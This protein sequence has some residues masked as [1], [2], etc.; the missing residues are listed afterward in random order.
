MKFLRSVVA[1]L[2][3]PLTSR[4][5]SPLLF[6]LPF[7]RSIT[8]PSPSSSSPLLDSFQ[9]FH[10]YL[11]MSIT[12]KCNLRCVYCMPLDGVRLTAADK[13]MTLNERTRLISI[14][15]AHGVNKIRFTGGEPTINKTL[16]DLIQY[17]RSLPSIQS[18]GITTNGLVLKPQLPKLIAAGLTHVNI[19][20]D[21]LD[22]IKYEQISRR[23]RKGLAMILSSL[24]A[25]AASPNLSVKI[26][27]VLMRNL[28]YSEILQFVEMTRSAD[29]D[30]RFIEVMP[31]EDNHWDPQQLV[32]YFEVLDYLKE[33]VSLPPTPLPRPSLE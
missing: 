27:C 3:L 2:P 4:R 21:T 8:T 30:V 14:F 7:S 15:A 23:D 12:E 1:A 33:Q 9:R 31:F 19:S 22:P 24:Y 13:L 10:N 17:C 32:P 6:R 5:L 11:R 25:A 28:N 18:I 20:L 16:P 26:N 29:I